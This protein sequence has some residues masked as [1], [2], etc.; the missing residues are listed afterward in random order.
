MKGREDLGEF[1]VSS[2]SPPPF[3]VRICKTGKTL[4][5]KL[6]CF[7]PETAWSSKLVSLVGRE[8][9]TP[10]GPKGNYILKLCRLSG[11]RKSQVGFCTM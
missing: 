2:C 3:K 8:N 6:Q 5:D 1:W 4:G 7:I 11:P 9:A 10:A